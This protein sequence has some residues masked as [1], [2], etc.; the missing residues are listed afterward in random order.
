MTSLVRR[1]FRGRN[2]DQ[3]VT[4]DGNDGQTQAATI[5]VEEPKYCVMASLNYLAVI[6]FIGLPMWYYTC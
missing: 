3:T 4:A 2:A 1:L 6:L 5:L